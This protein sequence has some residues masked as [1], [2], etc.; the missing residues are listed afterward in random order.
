M[1]S[2]AG[3]DLLHIVDKQNIVE[4]IDKAPRLACMH[5]CMSIHSSMVDH[6]HS[7]LQRFEQVGMHASEWAR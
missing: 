6:L 7:I 4:L 1:R 3:T 5:P 2:L